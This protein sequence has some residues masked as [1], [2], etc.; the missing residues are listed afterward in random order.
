MALMLVT[1]SCGTT[2]P[3][4]D[5]PQAD[6]FRLYSL[7]KSDMNQVMEINVREARAYLRELMEKLYKRNP[8]ELAK[9][10]HPDVA[11]SVNRIFSRTSNW[12]FQELNGVSGAQA[13]E[14][15][16]MPG[17]KGDRVFCYILGLTS[18]VM[19]SYRYK[20]EFFLYDSV[21]SQALY[22]SARNIELA[23]W[24]LSEARDIEGRPLIYSNSLPGEVENRSYERLFGKLI[25][26]Q[27]SLAMV[28]AGK[29]NRMIKKIIQRMATAVFLPI[30]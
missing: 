11:E 3:I 2:Q 25:A 13:I 21:D 28:M 27:D 7:G 20:T 16:L 19:A 1:T 6:R 17:F 8:R 14:L 9:S 29:N 12:H 4:E 5:G 23:V 18:M 30:P 24:K 22:N 10:P 26:L 15:S